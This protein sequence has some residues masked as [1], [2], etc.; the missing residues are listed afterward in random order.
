MNFLSRI[1]EMI[2]LAVWK[3][4]D[5]AYGVSIRKQVEKDTGIP[6]ISGAIYAPLNRLKKNGYVKTARRKSAGGKIGRPCIYYEL[7]PLGLNK[8]TAA[9]DITRSMW[10]QVPNLKKCEKS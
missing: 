4:K 3:L 8:L 6:W 10:A 1:E 2:L 5:K 9:Q 7:T